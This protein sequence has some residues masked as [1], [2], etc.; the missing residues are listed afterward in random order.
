MGRTAKT[1][2]TYYYTNYHK[3]PGMV[4][5]QCRVSYSQASKYFYIP[6]TLETNEK[7]GFIHRWQ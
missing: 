4:F 5:G 6:S 7:S 3:V 1:L 2:N